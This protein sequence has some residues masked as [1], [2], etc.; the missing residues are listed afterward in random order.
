[1]MKLSTNRCYQQFHP[2]LQIFILILILLSIVADGCHTPAPAIVTPPTTHKGP[3]HGRTE[4]VYIIGLY[5]VEPFHFQGFPQKVFSKK[6]IP[7]FSPDKFFELFCILR[8]RYWF[9][10]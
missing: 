4:I 8:R 5:D 2:Q 9:D 10:G 1:M 3:S 6:V 7:N